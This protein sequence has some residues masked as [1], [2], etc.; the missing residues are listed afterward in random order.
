MNAEESAGECSKRD[1]RMETQASS[2][3][4]ETAKR[5]HLSGSISSP[6]HDLEPRVLYQEVVAASMREWERNM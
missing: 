3:T 2:C 4:E 5:R 1:G 6:F